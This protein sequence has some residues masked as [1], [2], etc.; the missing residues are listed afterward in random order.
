MGITDRTWAKLTCSKCGKTETREALEKGSA[1][2][3]SWGDFD[4]FTMFNVS[5][6]REIY[7]PEVASATCK[8][9]NLPAIITSG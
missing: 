6:K 8:T 4:A 3:A 7:G 9:C 5:V 1:Y 2:G